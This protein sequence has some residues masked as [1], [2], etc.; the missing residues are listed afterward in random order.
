MVRRSGYGRERWMLAGGSVCRFAGWCRSRVSVRRHLVGRF[1]ML[2][3]RSGRR[4]VVVLV[5]VALL[6]SACGGEG[7]PEPE[8]AAV[9]EPGAAEPAAAAE[10]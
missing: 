8:E 9:V 3:A 6:G 5:A 4:V 7:A 2:G 10:S 1:V